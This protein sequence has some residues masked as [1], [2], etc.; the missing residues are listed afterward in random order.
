MDNQKIA[1][2]FQ[3]MGDMLEIQGANRFRVLAYQKAARTIADLPRELNDIYRKDPGKLEE[4]PGIGKDLAGKIVELLKTGK[5]RAHQDML[6]TFDRGLL[7]ILRVRGVGPK[8]VQLFYSKLGIDSIVKLKKAA[9]HG[10]LR[11]LPGMGEK[12]ESEVLKALG[13]YAMHQER[14]LLAVALHTAE[15]IVEYMKKC[16]FVR[17]VEYAG[18]LRRMK[19]TVGDIDVLA[20]AKNPEKD[21]AK[22]MDFFLKYPEVKDVIARGETKS[23]VILKNG[24]Q[25]DLRVLDEKIYGAALHYFTGS[26]AHNVM[27]R[28]RAKK[29]GMKLN[30]YGIFKVTRG[31]EKLIGGRTEEEV[32]KIV[33]LPYI[34]PELREDRG[35]IEAGSKHKLP[36]LIELKDLRGDLHV[37]S[38]WSDGT[39]EIEEIAR[40]YR[41]AGFEYIVMSDHSPAVAVA[42]GLT[43]ERF[44]MQWDEIDEINADFEKEAKRSAGLLKSARTFKIF[45][46]VECDILPDGRM[47]LPDSILKKMDIVIASV[48]SRFNMSEKEM[49]ERVLNAFKN[50]YVK[51]FGHPSGRLINR[52]E[53]YHIDMEKIIDA[54][55]HRGIAL[56]INS[57]PDR[58]DLQDYYCKMARD[59]GAKFVVNSDGHNTSQMDFLRYGMAVARRGWLTK[60]DVINTKSLKDLMKFFSL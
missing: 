58:L 54:A 1:E 21:H 60:G 28:D 15:K 8:K 31:G 16:K 18:S 46:G 47:D 37:H 12:S 10:Q 40:G 50:P 7:E 22:I 5:C 24:V 33:G 4:L 20:A 43:S 23:A 19:D 41:E 26:K 3:E 14:M 35:E 2:I 39:Q 17:R 44:K 57:Q 38:R 13:E 51:I 52:R 55:V 32:F 53:P 25:S 34:P 56:E 48:H 59:R 42:H 9:A 45:K 49:T 36:D 6:K 27:V 29:M 11:D 30:E